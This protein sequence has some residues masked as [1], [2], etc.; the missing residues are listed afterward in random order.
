MHTGIRYISS[1]M[2]VSNVATLAQTHSGF[3]V[4][5]LFV[6]DTGK[7]LSPGYQSLPDY[8]S[9]QHCV[10]HVVVWPLICD[11]FQLRTVA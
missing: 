1:Y 2:Y 11:M 9:S 3:Q 4:T 8:E 5:L 10:Q 6:A 7:S